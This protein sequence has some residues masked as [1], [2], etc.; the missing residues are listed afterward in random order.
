MALTSLQFE[1]RS[2]VLRAERRQYRDLWHELSRTNLAEAIKGRKELLRSQGAEKAADK[3]IITTFLGFIVA[4]YSLF[5]Q[6]P[7]SVTSILRQQPSFRRSFDLPSTVA[8][9]Y[10]SVL[11]SLVSRAEG[12]ARVRVDRDV[13]YPGQR[14]KFHLSLL[15]PSE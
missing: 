9:Q 8:E 14:A 3:V 13:L 10:L 6:L 2:F 4:I 12:G 1:M 11:S 7:S 5:L 15:C